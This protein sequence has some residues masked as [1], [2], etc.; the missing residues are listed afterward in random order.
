MN[1]HHLTLVVQSGHCPFNDYEV[2][3]EW[4][5]RTYNHTQSW[6]WGMSTGRGEDES[7][8]KGKISLRNSAED[9]E[10]QAAN[11]GGNL[12]KVY[13]RNTAPRPLFSS[14]C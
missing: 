2:G 1:G 3:S 10:N 14:P 11:N 12:T 7:D 4:N 9:L 13:H 6:K 8:W 5:L